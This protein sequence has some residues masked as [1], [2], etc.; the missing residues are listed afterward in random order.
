MLS[1]NQLVHAVI[2]PKGPDSVVSLIDADGVDQ[3]H[4]KVRQPMRGSD[5]TKLIPEGYSVLPEEC[6]VV[7]T[8]GELLVNKGVKFDTAVVTERPEV[9]FEERLA[10]LE[11]R[12]R[13]RVK[14][15]ERMRLEYERRLAG[16]VEAR[17]TPVV[18]ETPP[19]DETPP[20][21]ADGAQED[22]ES[23]VK[24]EPAE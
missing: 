6:H 21:G 24:N 20:E 10:A 12:E 22:A 19:E 13:R 5:I 23:G 2:W 11:R 7:T 15:E 1:R 3:A 16:A 4:V 8:S 14:R 18:E 17:A 9:P